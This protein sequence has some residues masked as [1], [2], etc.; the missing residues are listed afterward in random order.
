MDDKNLR[1]VL[2]KAQ[3]GD[4]EALNTIIDL[5]QPL[6]HKNSFVGGEFNEDCYQELIIKL[7]KCI[8]SF[9]SSSCNNVSK[10]LEKH[11]K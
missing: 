11:L 5:F 1:K 4:E 2:N 9:D 8:K 3:K 7:M 10:S 6:L